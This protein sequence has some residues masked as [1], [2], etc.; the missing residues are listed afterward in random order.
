VKAP[1][2]SE[3]SAPNEEQPVSG[4]ESDAPSGERTL[5]ESKSAL[6]EAAQAAIADQRIKGRERR[7]RWEQPSR[8]RTAF[9]STLG[10]L[11]LGGI[12]LLLLRPSW[13]V[14]P[15]LPAENPEVQAASAT[16]AL[17]DAASH[18]R[19]YQS[20]TGQFPERLKDAGITDAAIRYQRI[21]ADNFVIRLTA[22][23]ST[24]TLRSTD[25]IR[26]LVN[27]AVR[28]LRRRG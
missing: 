10:A 4:R 26:P 15:G 28:A 21:D 1:L 17:I 13:L 6:L 16:L 18:L 19:A 25:S 24:V 3:D 2:F 20:A 12:T 7:H 11:T 14:G 9:R 5:R 8:A 23:D 27:E 22:G